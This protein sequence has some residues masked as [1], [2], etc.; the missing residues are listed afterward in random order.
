MLG[1]LSESPLNETIGHN[2][3]TCPFSLQLWTLPSTSICYHQSPQLRASFMRK[4]AAKAP[5]KV[6][7]K[8]L[9]QCF[10]PFG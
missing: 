9:G 5:S 2:F 10:G 7:I 3:V 6:L 4:M 8:C 1:V